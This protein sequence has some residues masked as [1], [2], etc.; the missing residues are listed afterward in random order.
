MKCRFNFWTCGNMQEEFCQ[1]CID[2]DN[3][4]PDENLIKMEEDDIHKTEES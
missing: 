2:G 4:E 1:S 3:Y